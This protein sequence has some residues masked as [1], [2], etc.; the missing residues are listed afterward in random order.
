MPKGTE[1]G[2]PDIKIRALSITQGRSLNC[3]ESWPDGEFVGRERGVQVR[4]G[5]KQGGGLTARASCFPVPRRQLR[6]LSGD[7]RHLSTHTVPGHPHLLLCV[8]EEEA[9]VR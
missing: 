4:T 6:V 3:R 2:L 7:R 5:A 1:P 8:E 9:A